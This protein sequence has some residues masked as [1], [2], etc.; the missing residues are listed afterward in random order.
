MLALLYVLYVIAGRRSSP[1][2]RR[3]C[4]PER[5]RVPLP[6][7][8][9]AAQ[10]RCRPR[11]RSP[12]W[13]AALK[14]RAQLPQAPPAACCGSC[15]SLLLPGSSLVRAAGRAP[16]T[17]PWRRWTW[18]Q[19]AACRRS[20]P[21]AARRGGRGRPAGAAGRNQGGLQEPPTRAK[22]AAGAAR[23]GGVQE[24]PGAAAQAPPGAR[25]RAA[26]EPG[27]PASRGAAAEPVPA[28][29]LASGS[30]SRCRRWRCWPCIY[31][32]LSFAAVRDLQDAAGLV[33]PAGDA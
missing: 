27:L 31:W 26:A 4:R 7:R 3:R 29:Y 12:A 32:L 15:S 21:R 18:R 13:S 24:P 16:A 30:A 1:A 25:R 20:A 5:P 14:G 11:M 22:A 33:L 23:R 8:G 10:R 17:T 19:V 2:W 28:L 9:A 6:P